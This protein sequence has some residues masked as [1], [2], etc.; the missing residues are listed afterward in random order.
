L[1]TAS[2]Y[3]LNINRNFTKYIQCIRDD[4]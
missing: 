4:D 3:K 2:S 1:I